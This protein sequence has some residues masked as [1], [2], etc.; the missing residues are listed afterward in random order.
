MSATYMTGDRD[1]FVPKL[2]RMRSRGDIAPNLPSYGTA[3]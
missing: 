3:G 2:G 1:E